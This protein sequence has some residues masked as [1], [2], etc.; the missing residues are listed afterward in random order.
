[1]NTTP[2]APDAPARHKQSLFA[3]DGILVMA[4]LVAVLAALMFNWYGTGYAITKILESEATA[5]AARWGKFLQN[6]LA[7]MDDIL[8]DGTLSFGDQD[9]LL[10]AVNAGNIL[11]YKFF[12]RNGV[13]VLASRPDDVG[14][15]STSA[16]FKDVVMKGQTY[17][18]IATD[19]DFE[20]GQTYIS[21]AYIPVME[22][23]AFKGAIEV[24]SDVTGRAFEM[25]E[26]RV[27]AFAIFFSFTL[28]LGAVLAVVVVRN[29]KAQQLAEERLGAET[30]LRIINEELEERVS[31]RTQDLEQEI[32]SHLKTESELIAAMETAERANAAKSAFLSSVSHELRTPMNAIMGFAQMLQRSAD[33]KLDVRS[34]DNIGQIIENGDKLVALIDQILDLSKLENNKSAIDIADVQ[35][36]DIIH[37]CVDHF[38]SDADGRGL[39]ISSIAHACSGEMVA[40]DRNCLKQALLN[41]VSNAIKYNRDG[42]SVTISCARDPSE[43][44]TIS[45]SDTGFGIPLAYHESVFQP[46]RRLGR[47]ATT[48]EGAGVGLSISKALIELMGGRIGFTSEQDVGSTFWIEVPLSPAAMPATAR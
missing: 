10:N 1:M 28:L 20:D 48:I 11:R 37:E 22:N 12:D 41:L 13:I 34:R 15:K 33:G 46:F 42:G 19:D 18:K 31:Q 40:V 29:R 47:E 39:T 38:Q 4:T 17:T 21:E 44:M 30:T 2:D 36:E 24:Y 9:A 16:Y 7:G 6:D 23:G 26:Y 25:R 14:T 3:G 27:L 8:L 5:K 35:I 32:Q 43:N 45:V